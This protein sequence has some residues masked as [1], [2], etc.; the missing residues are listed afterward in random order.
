MDSINYKEKVV[1]YYEELWNEHKK[2]LIETL[3]DDNLTFRGSLDIETKGK[4]GFEDYFDKLTSGIPELYHGIEVMV[5]EKNIVAA[6]VYYHGIHTG[7]L[8]EL[9]P[10]GKTIRYSGA[11]FFKFYKD[12]IKDIW[13]LGDL[14]N[15]QRQLNVLD[16]KNIL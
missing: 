9:E 11:S 12:K 7:K 4:K 16:M 5:C 15:L 6:R 8:F 14:L 13:V 10:T 1:L 3:F 2:E